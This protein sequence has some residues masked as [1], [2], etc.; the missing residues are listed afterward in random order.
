MGNRS[1][2]AVFS[3][4]YL[5]VA[6]GAELAVKE[7]TDRIPGRRFAC[8][9]NHFGAQAPR[10]ERVGNVEVVRVGDGTPYA[11]SYAGKLRYVFLAWRAAEAEHRR[12]PFH[13]TWIIMASYGSLAALLFKFRHPRVPLLLT[14]QEGD[15]EEHIL[16]RVGIFYPVWKLVFRLAGE[17]QAISNFLAGFAKRHGAKRVTVVPNGVDLNKFSALHPKPYPPAPEGRGSL[18]KI[19]RL[20]PRVIITTSR[21]VPKN[22]ID[23]LIRAFAE[24]MRRKSSVVS[25]KLVIV[26]DGP[27]RGTLEKLAR[28]LGV[29]DRTEFLGYVPAERVPEELSRADVFVRPSRSEGLGSSFLEAMAAGV[30]VIATEVGGIRDFLKDGETGLAVRPEDPGDVAEKVEMVFRNSRL[31]SRIVGNGM[32]LVEERYAWERIAG[33]MDAIFT[34]L[35]RPAMVVA[36]GIFPPDIGGPA[37]YAKFLLDHVSVV[38]ENPAVVTYGN[39]STDR[40]RGV[41]VIPITSPKGIRHFIY[42]VELIRRSF[43]RGYIFAVDSSIGAAGVAAAAGA[44]TRAKLIVRVTGDYAWEQSRQRFGVMDGINEFQGRRYGFAVEAFRGVCKRIIRS[45]DRVIVPSE[46]LKKLAVGWGVLPGRITV[47]PNPVVVDSSIPKG[48][49]RAKLGI[50]GLLIVSAGRFVPWKGFGE[51]LQIFPSIRSAFPGATLTL[52]GDGP[53]RHLLEEKAAGSGVREAIRFTG[54]LSK[55]Q[56]IEWLSAADLFVLNSSYEGLSH[57]LIEAVGGFGLPAVATD[58]GGNP[59]VQ[60][61]FPDRV[62]IVETGNRAELLKEITAALRRKSPVALPKKG[63]GKFS[64]AAVAE[65]LDNFFGTL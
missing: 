39:S 63:A 22:G 13:A 8:F 10:R 65:D 40:S 54:S 6:G 14:L 25:Y 30:P 41:H 24:L 23:I 43:F 3:Y 2:I 4:A 57:Q 38:Q 20:N 45:A 36:T 37:T 35:L 61:E 26:G 51:I 42:F 7:I 18:N 44:V 12:D 33:E 48:E 34:K 21:L 55:V 1:N 49:A 58:A 32:R 53:E 31:R 52:I 15:T 17:V 64:L 47:I 46:Y 28:E 50:K 62:A 59:E 19:E 56:L 16:G 11:T 5:P 27:D 29:L 60:A 9:T